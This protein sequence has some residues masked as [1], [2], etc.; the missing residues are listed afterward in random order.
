MVCYGPQ[1]CFLM[2]FNVFALVVAE[3]YGLF[4]FSLFF[5]CLCAGSGLRSSGEV[6]GVL[7]GSGRLLDAL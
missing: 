6:C 4:C 1:A 5:L 3:I 2:F 7:G